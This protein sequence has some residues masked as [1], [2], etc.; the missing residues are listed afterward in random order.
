MTTKLTEKHL[1]EN[2]ADIAMHYYARQ[3]DLNGRF[4]FN[5][6]NRSS[7]YI[8]EKLKNMDR[9][10]AQFLRCQSLLQCEA[11]CHPGHHVH[12]L[13]VYNAEDTG[14]YP[15]SELLRH[16]AVEFCHIH[17]V[18]LYLQERR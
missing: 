14:R 2:G 8:I 1:Q 4:K 11:G 15:A 13:Q 10:P 9:L 12:Q 17:R 18:R 6:Y 5:C 3:S 16:S 7:R